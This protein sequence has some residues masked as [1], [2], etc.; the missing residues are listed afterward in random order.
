[1]KISYWLRDDG[2]CGYYRITL[3]LHTSMKNDKDLSLCELTQGCSQDTIHNSFTGDITIV[4]RL[5]EN[6]IV[7]FYREMQKEG[8][9]FVLDFDD[10]MFNVSPMSP[11]YGDHG[12]E[13]VQIPV[14]GKMVPLWVDGKNLDIEK[15][16]KKKDGMI[17]AC[18]QADM[19][20]VTTDILADVYR[21]F[22]DNIKVL[23][24]CVDLNIWKKLSFRETD[25]VRLVWFGG[26]S[27]YEDWY[28][29]SEPIKVVMN[30]YKNAKLVLMGSKW[31]YTLEGI[32][33]D[34]I[35]YHNWV[36]TPAYPYKAAIL[37]PDIAIIPL[38][39]TVFNRCKSP[40]KWVEMGAL[41][42]P[43]VVSH[44]PPYSTVANYNNGVFIEG[45]NKDAWIEG[46]SYLIDN[47]DERLMIGAEAR[48]TVDENFDISTQWHRWTDAYKGLM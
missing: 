39:D 30:K 13:E 16:K 42:V 33:H 14:K 35:E 17:K 34:Q 37:N 6:K 8:M 11:H 40:I 9:K 36:P 19:I 21:E 38:R 7:E 46:I 27:H 44:I 26:H 18:M 2:A 41:G 12:I 25:E 31:D 4:A 10:D 29:I 24:N 48:K 45:N 1:M 22:N 43:A 23:P 32:N 15:N 5:A 28:E 47:K 3:P 20:T